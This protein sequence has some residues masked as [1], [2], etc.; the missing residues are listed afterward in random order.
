MS[1]QWTDL[2]CRIYGPDSILFS[3]FFFIL[4]FAF[5]ILSIY[6]LRYY[7]FSI[8]FYVLIFSILFQV[9]IYFLHQYRV[10]YSPDDQKF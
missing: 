1:A 9:F 6:L 7:F 4:V 2:R 3:M 10:R 8:F 5:S